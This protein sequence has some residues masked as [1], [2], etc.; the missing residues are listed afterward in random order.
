MS[1]KYGL[2]TVPS[3]ITIGDP[4]TASREPMGRSRLKGVNMKASKTSTG[5]LND[6][7]FEN[8]KPLYEVEKYEQTWNERLESL[9]GER[10]RFVTERPWKPSS[11]Q[12]KTSGPGNYYGCIGG[13]HNHQA[14]FDHHVKKKGAAAARARP[15]AIPRRRADGRGSTDAPRR[16]P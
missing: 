5:K 16:R 4:Y 15:R 1:T 7:T 12:K 3:Y 2:F 10:K 14:E 8:F 6:A 9:S 11:P 13:V